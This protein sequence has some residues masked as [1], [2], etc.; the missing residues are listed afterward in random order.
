MKNNYSESESETQKEKYDLNNNNSIDNISNTSYESYI[1]SEKSYKQNQNN[2]ANSEQKEPWKPQWINENELE[3]QNDE[4]K[5][6]KKI[7]IN[8]TQ[9]DIE[10][11][12]QFGNAYGNNKDKKL[13]LD[14]DDEYYCTIHDSRECQHRINAIRAINNL[15]RYCMMAQWSEQHKMECWF[16]P[17]FVKEG[18]DEPDKSLKSDNTYIYPRCD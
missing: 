13:I 18:K 7:K 2:N 3:L 1:Y 15:C 17:N 4:L 16:I 6:E 12:K 14:S 9:I 8:L 11:H 5:E 10:R